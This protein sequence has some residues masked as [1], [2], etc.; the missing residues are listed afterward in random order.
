MA[1]GTLAHSP[2]SITSFSRATAEDTWQS[3]IL[4]KGMEEAYSGFADLFL[5]A[6]CKELAVANGTTPH[7]QS[8]KIFS[9]EVRTPKAEFEN[10]L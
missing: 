5:T 9:D 10:S 8:T 2:A 1:T 4:S 3:S 6:E 7:A